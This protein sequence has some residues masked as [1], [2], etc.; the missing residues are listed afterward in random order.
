MPKISAFKF[1][2]QRIYYYLPVVL[3]KILMTLWIFSMLWALPTMLSVI[4]D[5]IAHLAQ[6]D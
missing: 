1:Q 6:L 2:Q 4:T 3:F 5:S